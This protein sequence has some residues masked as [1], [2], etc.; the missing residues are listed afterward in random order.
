[1][2]NAD[3]PPKPPSEAERAPPKREPLELNREFRNEELAEER[4]KLVPPRD[5][6]PAA[7]PLKCAPAKSDP[8]RVAVD[9]EVRSA[10]EAPLAKL[11]APLVD[12]PFAEPK[13]RQPPAEFP[14]L[15]AERFE[16][17]EPAELRSAPDRAELP[18]LRAELPPELPNECHWPSAM[19]EGECDARFPNELELRPALN[20][21][22]RAAVPRELLK[23]PMD[24]LPIA[25]ERADDPPPKPRLCE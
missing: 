13:S 1:L 25:L 22:L 19:A 2:P 11:D 3:L 8:A 10:L 18:K 6:W 24:R 7:E 5:E 21:P 9:G 14:A 4:L 12:A 23:P 16:F 17:A 20:P 15:R